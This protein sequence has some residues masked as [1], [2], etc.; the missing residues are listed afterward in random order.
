[1][2]F[3][4][5]AACSARLPSFHRMPAHPFRTDY[6]VIRELQNGDVVAHPDSQGA[7][8]APFADHDADRRRGKL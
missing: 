5:R 7:S 6:G 4:A 2:S 8:R 1:M 3:K